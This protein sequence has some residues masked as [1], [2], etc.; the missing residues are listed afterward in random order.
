VNVIVERAIPY[1]EKEGWRFLELDVYRPAEQDKPL[2]L[3]HYIHGGGWRR[4]SRQLAPRETRAWTPTLFEQMVAAGFVVA[5]S[6]YRFSGEALYPAAI[7][8]TT[9][10]LR[11]LR[12][13]ADR[14]G[15][16]ASR[17]VLFGQSGGG[18][19]ALAVGLSPEL[20][21]VQGIVA[22]YPVTDFSALADDD[23]ASNFPSM[24]LGAPLSSVPELV[25]R[26]RLPRL[27]RADAPPVLLQHGTADSMAPFDQSVRMHDALAAAGAPVEFDRFDGAEHFFEGC[28]DEEVRAI[29]ERAM[30]FART[31]VEISPSA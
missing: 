19:L 14:F 24:W 6:D 20:E 18:Y 2:P 15:I 23:P 12:A 21:P 22:W 5:A 1:A 17:V 26:A 10:A 4:S 8:D 9:D 30:R 11:W 25:E 28:D 29:F 3:L 16:D 31:C 13:H 27:A 7:E